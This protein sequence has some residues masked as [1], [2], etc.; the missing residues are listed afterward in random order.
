M[1]P[2]PHYKLVRDGIP[3]K[4]DGNGV[5]FSSRLVGPEEL[6]AQ[7]E[8]KIVEELR[9][10]IESKDPR[11]LADVLEVIKC[12]AEIQGVGWEE[13]ES[14]RVKKASELGSF[15]TGVYLIETIDSDGGPTSE[16]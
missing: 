2:T 7:L 15:L 10:Y 16:G 12:M 11:E 5:E 9:E 6:P 3:T 8:L 13:L 4:L 1:E 14:M